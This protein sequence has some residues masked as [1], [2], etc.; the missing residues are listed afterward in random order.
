MPLLTLKQIDLLLLILHVLLIQCGGV[1]WSPT[2]SHDL[3]E[4][5]LG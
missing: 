2:K 1:P 4:V 3:G 5:G